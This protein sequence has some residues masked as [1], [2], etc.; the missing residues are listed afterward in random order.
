LHRR[1]TR[2]ASC[3]GRTPVRGSRNSDS[4]QTRLPLLTRGAHDLPERQQTLRST[5][6]WSYDL[7]DNDARRVFCHLSVFA[8]GC[9]LDAAEWICH[10]LVAEDAR[11]TLPATH[12]LDLLTDLVEK[13]LIRTL[14]ELGDAVRFSML[15][16]VREYSGEQLL[17]AGE[18]EAARQSHL[19]GCLQFAETADPLLLS[20]EQENWQA[21]LSIEHDNLRAALSGALAHGDI[22]PALRLCAALY[23]F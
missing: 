13:S 12:A 18:A 23:R 7:L 6:A 10:A 9:T 4:N 1:A 3:T 14:P 5:L 20:T 8:G 16:T 22:E 17:A 15:V 19:A 21:R 2:C 11:A